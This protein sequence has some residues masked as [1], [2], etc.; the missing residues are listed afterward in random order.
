MG[1]LGTA[2]KNSRRELIVVLK[3]QIGIIDHTAAVP[4]ATTAGESL[5]SLLSQQ[6]AM[7][8]P[9][10][11]KPTAALGSSGLTAQTTQDS[12]AARFH[13]VIAPDRELESIKTAILY[14]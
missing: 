13:E 9:I 12:E 10:F 1:I 11:S 7:I 5:A 2:Q 3:P 14:Y 4:A 6:G 8:R